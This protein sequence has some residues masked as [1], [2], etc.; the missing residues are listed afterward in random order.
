MNAAPEGNRGIHQGVAQPGS[1]PALGAGGREF[2]S[3]HPDQIIKSLQTSKV[4]KFREFSN[5]FENSEHYKG[6]SCSPLE[7]HDDCGLPPVHVLGDARLGVV[8][9][10]L[11]V[12]ESGLSLR[13]SP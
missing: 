10:F 7:R 4:G 8:A 2:E 1:A 12:D 5:E 6:L 13:L 11:S 3:H 9:A